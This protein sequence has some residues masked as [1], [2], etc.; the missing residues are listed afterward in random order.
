M[1]LREIEN[2]FQDVADARL[3]DENQVLSAE[4]VSSIFQSLLESVKSNV[5]RDLDLTAKM[6]V[7]AIH[8]LFEEADAQDAE[9][10]MDTSRIEDAALIEA[11]DNI[12]L[13]G[14]VRRQSMRSF[15]RGSFKSQQE[16]ESLE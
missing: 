16:P 8:Q 4:E 13:D 15:G 6:S 12:Q 10:Q 9:L 3:Q 2:L 14:E 5:N 7:V 1:Q 11:I